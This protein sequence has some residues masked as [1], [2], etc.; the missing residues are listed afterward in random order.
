MESSNQTYSGPADQRFPSSHTLTNVSLTL[1]VVMLG[2]IVNA[3]VLLYLHMLK[4][5]LKLEF[6][7]IGE[8]KNFVVG[9]NNNIHLKILF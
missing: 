2:E 4:L 5:V 8:V 9:L 7:Y 3:F 6:Q 1:V